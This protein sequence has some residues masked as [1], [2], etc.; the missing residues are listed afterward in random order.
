MIY[1]LRVYVDNIL[2]H[3]EMITCEHIELVEI[4]RVYTEQII[5]E[6]TILKNQNAK[7]TSECIKIVPNDVTQQTVTSKE[8]LLM[9]FTE[10]R[11]KMLNNI[12][13]MKSIIYK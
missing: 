8:H 6:L 13:E 4:N 1:N 3:D 7:I 9:E 5:R 2:E 11:G 12:A 10:Y